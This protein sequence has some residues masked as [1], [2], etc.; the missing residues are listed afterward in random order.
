MVRSIEPISG[1]LIWT[2]AYRAAGRVHPAGAAHGIGPKST[3]C[4]QDGR[5][6]TLGIGS[7]LSCF[8][9]ATGQLNWRQNYDG[10]FP[11]SAPSCG[12]SMSPLISD[13]LCIV[14]VG[15]DRQGALIAYDMKTGSERWRYDDDGPGYGS[16]I[17][18]T[19]RERRQLITPVSKFIAGFSIQTGERLWRIPFPTKSTQN[20]LTPVTDDHGIVV[21]GIAQTT[22]K[23]VPSENTE[24]PFERAWE[25]R[26]MTM[27][28]SSPIRVGNRIIGNSTRDRGILFCLDARTGKLI[29]RSDEG[30]SRH[31][32]LTRL[33]NQVAALT[34]H[35]R[36]IVFRGDREKFKSLASYQV[37]DKS[38]WA[39]P[40]FL[41]KRVL[42][43]D[44]T[45]LTAWS[46]D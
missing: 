4:V 12:T 10:Q 36:L 3:P 6:Y 46:L 19:L 16:P 17:V 21:G 2:K 44:N 26:V 8:D 43:K 15:V 13:G 20:I 28:M 30:M 5:L 27:H 9:S 24:K 38:T 35:G 39:Y 40:L 31:V 29:W 34:E 33:G 41:G 14:H 42:I 32:T 11:R 37:S 23:L 22:A 45:S 25:N 1:K 18:T 7:I